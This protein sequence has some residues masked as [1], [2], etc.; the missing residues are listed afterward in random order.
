MLGYFCY[1]VPKKFLMSKT[2][3]IF[4]IGPMGVGKTTIGKRLARRLDKNFY[5]SDKEIVKK[6]GAAINLIFDIEGEP[7]FR[8]WESKIIDELTSKKGVVV[9]TGGGAILSASN[10]E[11]LSQRGIVIYLAASPELL[12]KRTA[13]DT[14]RPL[15]ETGDRLG[16]IKSILKQ[17]EPIYCQVADFTVN[18]DNM[19]ARQIINQISEIIDPQ[20]E[21]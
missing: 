16:K 11:M 19:S 3:N 18:V 10:R 4:I 17:R 14:T 6:T 13:H 9:A 21:K 1:I 15:L 2:E 7:G 12:L 5:D 8:D 20:C